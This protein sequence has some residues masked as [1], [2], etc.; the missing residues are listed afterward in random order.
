MAR[1]TI[2]ISWPRGVCPRRSGTFEY[3][4]KW[5]GSRKLSFAT[6]VPETRYFWT[7][8]CINL[9]AHGTPGR[10]SFATG[11]LKWGTSG[12]GAVLSF[13]TGCLPAAAR[14]LHKKA[15]ACFTV[16]VIRVS[17]RNLDN[18]VWQTV[19]QSF[20]VCWS[21]FVHL[22]LAFWLEPSAHVGNVVQRIKTIGFDAR[23]ARQ[24]IVKSIHTKP[25]HNAIK[26][27]FWVGV[28]VKSKISVICNRQKVVFN[29]SARN[30]QL[31]RSR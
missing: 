28:A 11:C 7:G 19:W 8:G 27:F 31:E 9:P 2:R 20:F 23:G 14:L 16:T 29:I 12:Q 18:A 4:R 6:G 21:V 24:P 15:L 26:F 1:L 22:D 17:S 10:V 13:A 25:S 5:G 30:V 3:S